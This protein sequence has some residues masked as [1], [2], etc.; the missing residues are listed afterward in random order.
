MILGVGGDKAKLENLEQKLTANSHFYAIRVM[1]ERVKAVSFK[2]IIKISNLMST[3][4][5]SS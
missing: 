2:M 4:A 1:G 5:F 3:R